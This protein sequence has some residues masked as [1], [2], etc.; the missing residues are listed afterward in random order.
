MRPANADPNPFAGIPVVID[1]RAP[2]DRILALG[3]VEYPVSFPPGPFRIVVHVEAFWAMYYPRGFA[4]FAAELR[5][6]TL[7]RL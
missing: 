4:R 1:N 3:G 5:R 7:A 6:L 2:T